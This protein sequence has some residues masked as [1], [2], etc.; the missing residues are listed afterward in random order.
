MPY[1]ETSAKEA[2]NVEQGFEAAIRRI[3]ALGHLNI[4][5][6]QDYTVDLSNKKQNSRGCC[7]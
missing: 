5:K 1:Y 6:K 3:A 2:I 7:V 4:T